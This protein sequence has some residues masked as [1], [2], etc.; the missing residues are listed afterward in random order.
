MWNVCLAAVGVGVLLLGR[1]GDLLA[2]CAPKDATRQPKV[3]GAKPTAMHVLPESKAMYRAV[4]PVMYA[5]NAQRDTTRKMKRRR[6]VRLVCPVKPLEAE[7]SRSVR[8][9]PLGAT[10]RVRV[11]RSV[12]LWGLIV[13]MGL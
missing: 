9:V 11:R 7:A 12:V 10:V 1:R 3:R 6:I 5:I 13:R 2:C 8:V 4:N